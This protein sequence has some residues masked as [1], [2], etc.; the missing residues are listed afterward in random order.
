MKPLPARFSKD[1]K[2]LLSLE[3]WERFAGPK[4]AW[5]WVDGRS[6]KE[7]ARAWLAGGG[8]DGLPPEVSAVLRA[9]PRFGQLLDWTAEPEARLRFDRFPGEPR[10]SDLVVHAKDHFG[11]YLLAIEAKADEPYGDTLEKTLQAAMARRL[12][13]PRSKG[14]ARIEQLFQRFFH[15]SMD[16]LPGL[17]GLRYQLLT[18]CAG[19][20]VEAEHRGYGRAVMLVHEFI[21]DKTR[22][23]HHVRNAQDLLAFVNAVAREKADFLVPATLYGPFSFPSVDVGGSTELF[24][25]K[26]SRD[27]RSHAT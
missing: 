4:S 9:H 15:A 24:I 22:D 3:D 20:I 19:A 12:A 5:Q 2:P 25:G 10:N 18:A 8:D 27:L 6:A 21:T 17:V 23:E 14:L 11:P 26:V 7:A 16:A 13:N 1:R